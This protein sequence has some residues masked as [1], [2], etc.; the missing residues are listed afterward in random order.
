MPLIGRER[1]LQVL[2]A[3]FAALSRQVAQIVFVFGRTGTGKTAL[4]RAF[5]DG[6]AARDEAIVLFGR[7]Y[8]RE[9]VPYKALDSLIDALARHLKGL[10]VRDANAILPAGAAY[11]ARL[12]PVLEGV[13]GL[14][15]RGEPP[16]LPDQQELRRRAC[17]GLREVLR[18]LT[19]RAP[20]VLAIDDLQW[21]DVDSARLIADLIAAPMSPT[22]LLIGSFRAEDAESCPFLAELSRSTAGR[23]SRHEH[24]ELAVEALTQSEARELALA[25]LGRD[26]A[27]ARARA[28]VVGARVGRQPVVRR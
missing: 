18:R 17:D 22:L 12:F 10:S 24:R 7:C 15:E 8:E 20:L 19:A 25:L 27:V 6:L 3:A 9:S 1:H 4:I 23:S 5:L 2:D 14:S 16:E 11:L 13:P 21:G 28:H 26:D